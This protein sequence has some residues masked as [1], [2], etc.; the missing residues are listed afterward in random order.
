MATTVVGGT[1][2]TVLFVGLLFYLFVA[3]IRPDRF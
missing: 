2:A 1:V 3:L